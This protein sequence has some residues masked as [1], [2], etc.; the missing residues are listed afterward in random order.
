MEVPLSAGS[1]GQVLGTD[2][3]NLKFIDFFPVGSVYFTAT[4]INPSTFLNGVWTQIGKGKFI[5]SVG[6]GSDQN[7]G[8]RTLQEGDTGNPGQYSVTLQSENL[9]HYHGFGQLIPSSVFGPTVKDTSLVVRPWRTPSNTGTYQSQT[10]IGVPITTPGSFLPYE[11]DGDQLGT[12]DA[13]FSSGSSAHDNTPP[14]IGL[15]V[16]QRIS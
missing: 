16:W 1:Q 2:G 11:P 9:Q 12:S 3:S 14:Y 4:N 5:A 13:I 15:Y 6:T 7:G 10:L 8:S